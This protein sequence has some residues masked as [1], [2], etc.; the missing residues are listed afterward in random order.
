MN[1][2]PL[3]LRE[4]NGLA[5]AVK[6]PSKYLLGC[7]PYIFPLITFLSEIGSLPL[8][9]LTAGGGKMVW[10]PCSIAWSRFVTCAVDQSLVLAIKLSTYTSTSVIDVFFGHSVGPVDAG[11]FSV[12]NCVAVRMFCGFVDDV[13]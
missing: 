6:F 7:V 1:V 3:F 11:A 12:Q 4:F 10:M 9:P 13:P 5:D 8:C 2:F